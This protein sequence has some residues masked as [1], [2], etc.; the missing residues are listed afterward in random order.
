MAIA[1]QKDFAGLNGYCG[2]EW[3]LRD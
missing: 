2:I 3:I 1:G